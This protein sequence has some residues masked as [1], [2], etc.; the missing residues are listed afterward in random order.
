[1][2]GWLTRA[3]ISVGTCGESGCIGD[4]GGVSSVI[5]LFKGDEIGVDESEETS[6]CKLATRWSSPSLG[7]CGSFDCR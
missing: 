5:D 4:D 3:S 7:T 1:M 2:D 6:L